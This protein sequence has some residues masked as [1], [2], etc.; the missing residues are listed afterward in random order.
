[1]SGDSSRN[2]ANN[3]ATHGR[4]YRENFSRIFKGYGFAHYD[5]VDNFLRLTTMEAVEKVKTKMIKKL[6]RKKKI[7]KFHGEYLVVIDAT[8]V[9]SYDESEKK[10]GLLY[11]ESKTGKR[12]Y[13]NIILEA[14]IVTPEGLSLSIASEPLT[15]TDIESYEK[16]DCELKAFKR[17]TAK[18]K[19]LFP[20]LPICLLLDGL[21]ANGPVF[22]ICEKYLWHYIVVFKDGNLP[23]LQE[24][25]MDTEE[26]KRYRFDYTECVQCGK[27]KVYMDA[28]YQSIENLSYK[29]HKLHWIESFCPNPRQKEGQ[30]E[31]TRFVFLTNI[32]L[33]K[34]AAN[35]SAIIMEIVRAGRLRW[36][37]ENEGFNTQKHHGYHLHHKFSRYSPKVLHVYYILMQIAHIINQLVLHSKPVMALKK[38]Y[39]KLTTRY[40]WDKLRHVLEYTLLSMRQI[41]QS[42]QPAQIRLE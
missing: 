36:K 8:G 32:A 23:S 37:I 5:T 28:H 34:Q 4:Y 33:G 35:K 40:L 9:S 29:N 6:I 14:K 11:K 19:Q 15:N 13:L 1:M 41:N 16:Q 27:E 10:E 24:D 20:R 42:F 31:N 30:K 38:C 39:P 26:S 22:E 3:R 21:Y 17:I 12:T 2:S 25:I 7:P 18:I